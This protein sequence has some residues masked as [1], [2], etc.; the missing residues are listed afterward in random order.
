[1]AGD[2]IDFDVE[3]GVKWFR[4]AAESGGDI[5]SSFLSRNV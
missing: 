4:K 1:M 2:G 3:E 5:A